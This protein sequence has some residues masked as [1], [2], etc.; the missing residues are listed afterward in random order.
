MLPT[1]FIP[2][3][4]HSLLSTV[5][6]KRAFLIKARFMLLPLSSGQFY[7][8][9]VFFVFCNIVLHTMHQLL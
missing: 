1:L 4:P 9:G 6:I 5:D 8:P 3:S 7:E 2:S